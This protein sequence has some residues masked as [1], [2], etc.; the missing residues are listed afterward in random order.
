MS[1]IYNEAHTKK[2]L[3]FYDCKCKNEILGTG[4][5][6]IFAGETD[7]PAVRDY[8]IKEYNVFVCNNPIFDRV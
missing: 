3:L 7:S 1:T 5:S 6:A 4:G 8:M 2:Y